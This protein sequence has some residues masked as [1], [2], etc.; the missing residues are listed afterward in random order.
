MSS[1]LSGFTAV[2]NPQ[3]L[4]FMGAQSFIMM[5][6][7]GEGWQYGKRRISA[8]SNEDFNKLTPERLLQNQAATLRSSIGTIEK[9][10]NAMTPM[11]ETII[12]QYGEF[13]KVVIRETPSVLLGVT[14][15]KSPQEIMSQLPPETSSNTRN[16]LASFLENIIPNIPGAFG[17][18]E[19]TS[20]T[21]G[22]IITHVEDKPGSKIHGPGVQTVKEPFISK[23]A[24]AIINARAG[25]FEESFSQ[26][27]GTTGQMSIGKR[28]AVRKLEIMQN[29]LLT[30]TT[31]QNQ[32]LRQMASRHSTEAALGTRNFQRFRR[33]KTNLSIQIRIQKTLIARFKF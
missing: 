17:S 12:H 16:A 5:F 32:A 9:S 3:M 20:T 30:L 13:L 7:A 29:E 11:I 8:M 25:T 4:A 1:P 22:A 33:D 19:T 21:S 10:M 18:G 28:N 23:Q 2:P 6:Q 26:Q 31:K 14:G 15:G 27:V 24:Q